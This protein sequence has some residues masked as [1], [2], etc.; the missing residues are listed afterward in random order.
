MTELKPF[1]GLTSCLFLS[2]TVHV[3]CEEMVNA[4]AHLD[5]FLSRISAETRE[6]QELGR[7]L[8]DGQM[9]S[10]DL[11]QK[12]MEGL[13]AGLEEY[14]G[15]L[16][17]KMAR[18]QAENESLRRHLG[19]S[20]RRRRRMREETGAHAQEMV[21]QQAALRAEK[22]G[23]EAELKE[24]ALGRRISAGGGACC[25]SRGA[26]GKAPRHANSVRVRRSVSPLCAEVACVERTLH[27]RRAELREADRRLMHARQRFHSNQAMSQHGATNLK[28]MEMRLR[29]LQ[30]EEADLRKRTRAEHQWPRPVEAVLRE[31]EAESQG[32]GTAVV[33]M[34]AHECKS[35]IYTVRTVKAKMIH[36][37][38]KIGGM[39]K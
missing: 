12:D 19:D 4:D 8:A 14:V 9:L 38:Q 36:S 18:L 15:K 33:H 13:L 25:P 27:K 32:L 34:A 20:E 5:D 30:D 1:V 26:N 22:A 37:R 23:L 6:I 11:L 16:H 31:R 28:W 2:K 17:L 3:E 29:V 7:Q 35:N 21:R 24:L 10:K 39:T